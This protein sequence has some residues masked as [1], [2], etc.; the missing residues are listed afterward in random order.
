MDR[1]EQ[2]AKAESFRKLHLGHPIL[3]LPNVWDAASARVV[4]QAGFPALATSSA[5]VAASLGYA[6][7]ERI[8]IEEMLAAIQRIVRVVRVPVSADFEAGYAGSPEAVAESVKRLLAA[9]AIGLN[10]EDGTVDPLHP[11]CDLPLQVEKIQAI[12]NAVDRA[13]VPLVINARTDVYLGEVGEAAGRFQETVRR[14]NAYRDAGADCLFVPGVE[15]AATIAGL[16]REIHGPINILAGA[17]APPVAELERLGVA[18]VSFGSGPFRAS[19]GTLRRLAAELR[20]AGTCSQI[21]SA[22]ISFAEVQSLFERR[23]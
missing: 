4:E 9:G 15:D 1:A 19:L 11:L 3:V 7:G 5:G 16:A 10:F 13:G 2:R 14:A 22:A 23:G 12:R 18:R 17:G 6:D 20:A 21:L 8:P